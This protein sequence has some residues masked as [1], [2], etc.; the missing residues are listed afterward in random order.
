M[1]SPSGVPSRFNLAFEAFWNW[2]RIFSIF[3]W[4]RYM[5]IKY[6][7]QVT[8]K[9]NSYTSKTFKVMKYTIWIKFTEHLFEMQLQKK[10]N[11][12][13]VIL[14][15]ILKIS[16]TFNPSFSK[17]GTSTFV[18]IMVLGKSAS[19]WSSEEGQSKSDLATEDKLIPF[20]LL[21][22]TWLASSGESK[23]SFNLKTKQFLKVFLFAWNL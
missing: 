5:N 11:I 12:L 6:N 4:K 19:S 2:K 18:T 3:T 22:S 13:K 23:E 10:K 14:I 8:L 21:N 9:V 15:W 1:L 16:H 17:I 7:Y 20:I